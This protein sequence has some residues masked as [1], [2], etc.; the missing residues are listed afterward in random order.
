[1]RLSTAAHAAA[2]ITGLAW[3]SSSAFAEDLVGVTRIA[4]TTV[5]IGVDSE[6][7]VLPRFIRAVTGLI[8]NEQLVGIDV[9]PAD[10]ALIGVGSTTSSNGSS[11]LYSIDVSTGAAT[12]IGPAVN[13]DLTKAG[14]GSTRFGLD[15]NPTI[16]RVRLVSDADQN[17]VFN[18]DTGATTPATPLIYA[19]AD[20][21]FGQNPNVVDI[22]YDNN[23][24]GAQTSQQRGID[25]ARDVLVTVANNAGTLGTIGGLGVDVGEVGGF[26]VSATGVAY[27]AMTPF[28]ATAQRLYEINLQTGAATPKG[29]LALGLVALEGLT[30]LPASPPAASRSVAGR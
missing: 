28:G 21:N 25:S 26:D 20:P 5:L 10:G 13:P 8:G 23:V 24:A 16:D 27:A 30:A 1:M 7:P 2:A 6:R 3:C 22:A 19:P 9:R 11:H 18:P 12:V 14:D 4:N 15:F 29:I 17:I